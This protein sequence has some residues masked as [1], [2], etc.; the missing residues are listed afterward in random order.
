MIYLDNS[1][2]THKKPLKVKLALI[3][4]ISTLSVNPSRASYKRALIGANKVF[5]TREKLA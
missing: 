1:S 5:E 2:T 3:K 4:G